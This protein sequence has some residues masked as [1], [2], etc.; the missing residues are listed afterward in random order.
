MMNVVT[1]L[2]FRIPMPVQPMKVIATVAIAEGLNEAQ[3]LT[4]GISASVVVLLAAASGLVP[5]LHRRAAKSV[6]RGMQLA[7]GVKLLLEGV[8]MVGKTG[9]WFGA[10]SI[11]MAILAILVIG[12]L[13]LSKRF[14]AA[15]VVFLLGFV[16][17]V[18]RSPEFLTQLRLGMEWHL[19]DLTRLDDWQAGFV[20][21]GLP[22]IPLTIANSVIAVCALAGDLFPDRPLETR[23]VA[24][25]VALMNLI[26]CPFGGMPMCHGAGGLAAQYRFGARTGGSVVILGLAKMSL[27]LLFGSSLLLGLQQYPQS[28]LGVLLAFGGAELARV[29][30]DQTAR[31]DFLVM[32][33]T[34]AACLSINMLTGF[35]LGWMIG[36]FLSLISRRVS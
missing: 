12:G 24:I 6:I 32:L 23:R 9:E 16:A 18:F 13:S 34:A 21:A 25:S 20:R 10:D 3:V 30:R 28:V 7:L 2:L 5:W 14:P 29:C 15:L 27:A 1:G 19:P 8:Q 36:L 35:F 22:Q 17:L 4:A 26:C 33:L 31:I 11:G